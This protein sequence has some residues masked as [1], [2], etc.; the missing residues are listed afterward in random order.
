M[1]DT[2][3]KVFRAAQELEDALTDLY[4]SDMYG[5]LR[6]VEV[7]GSPSEFIHSAAIGAIKTVTETVAA[8]IRRYRT[9]CLEWLTAED[10]WL[11]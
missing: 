4:K 5:K 9:E 3:Q 2:V 11:A 1:S 10:K 7:P 6:H 8:G